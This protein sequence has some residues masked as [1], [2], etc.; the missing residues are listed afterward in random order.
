MF[1]TV[2]GLHAISATAGS[3]VL[4]VTRPMVMTRAAMASRGIRTQH[5]PFPTFADVSVC[6]IIAF[7]FQGP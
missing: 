6:E 7:A 3:S 4:K 1:L 2:V 5:W